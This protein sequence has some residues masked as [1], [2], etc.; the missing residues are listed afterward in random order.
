MR[1]GPFLELS[2][3][4][5][6]ENRK[7]GYA[8]F[9]EDL[10]YQFRSRSPS[11]VSASSACT[12]FR[13]TTQSGTRRTCASGRSYSAGQRD[14]I[15]SSRSVCLLGETTYVSMTVAQRQTRRSRKPRRHAE[16]R[17]PGRSTFSRR[18]I[19]FPDAG[20]HGGEGVRSQLPMSIWRGN[21]SWQWQEAS[22]KASEVKLSQSWPGCGHGSSGRRRGL[23]FAASSPASRLGPGSPRCA[24]LGRVRPHEHLHHDEHG[25]VVLHGRGL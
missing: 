18:T 22:D 3:R 9:Y 8:V 13:P 14:L 11:E 23:W 15:V 19:E 12:R 5:E 20:P 17:C 24:C 21:L 7:I 25:V 10:V 4:G 1:Q 2:I 6:R 16:I